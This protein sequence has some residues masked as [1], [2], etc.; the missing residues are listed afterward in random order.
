MTWSPH[1]SNGNESAKVRFDILP[2]VRGRGLDIGC[3]PWKVFAHAIGVDGQAY[4]QAGAWG[5]QLVMDVRSLDLFADRS[6]DWVYSSHTLEHV[7]DTVATLREWWRLVEVGGY[8][9]HATPLEVSEARERVAAV[10]E[11]PGQPVVALVPVG[12]TEP[13]WWPYTASLARRLVEEGC[14]VLVLGDLRNIEEVEIPGVHWLGLLPSMRQAMALVGQVDAVVG[15]ETGLLNAVAYNPGVAKVVLLSHSTVRNLTGDWVRIEALSGD[16]PCYPCHRIHQGW[17]FCMRDASTAAAAC[18][19][20][21]KPARV[22]QALQ[23]LGIVQRPI[24]EAA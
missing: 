6:F 15:Q 12:S 4:P 24:E 1:T 8:R 20:D 14:V 9:F 5:P 7:V 19:T 16:V 10:R 21:I 3:G 11:R 17:D 22:I 2:F 18:Q 23:R 13:K